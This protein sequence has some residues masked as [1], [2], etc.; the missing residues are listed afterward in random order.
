M[1]AV[2][3]PP[4]GAVKPEQA[5]RNPVPLWK[6]RD[7]WW[8]AFF[9]APQ[10]A[11]IL[12]FTLV[13]FAFSLVLAFFDWNGLGPMTFVGFDNLIAEI[14]D[15][16]F[17]RAVLNT[18]IIAA[19]T[20]PVGLFLAIVIAVMLNRVRS[21]T[22]YM[23]M[24]FAPVVTSSV[25]V[26][27]IWQQLLRTDGLLST[28][29]AKVLR[30]DPPDWLND[31]HLAL[32]AVCAVTIWSSLGL[33][34]VIFQAGLQNVNPSVLE[35]ASIDGAGTTRTFFSV[36]LPM[37]SPT[38]FFQSVIAFISSLQTFDLVFVLVKNAGPDN[39]T[40]TIVYHIYDLGFRKAQLG[41]SSAAAI[42]LLILSAL[43]TVFQFGMEK[44]FVHYDN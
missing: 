17:G 12:L 42:F 40:R 32:L 24:L 1:S 23:V 35:A 4:R 13:P 20:V 25:A 19:V 26:A 22:V 38:I 27:L 11:G 3:S 34:V 31:P 7:R 9:L 44:R 36:I 37:L 15:P 10:G 41:M 5:E 18:L 14:T 16:L 29:V 8:A 39:A 21:R 30:T 43:I 28:V 2:A 6:R 33:N